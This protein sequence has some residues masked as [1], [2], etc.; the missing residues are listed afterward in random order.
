MAAR[1]FFLKAIAPGLIGIMLAAC[2]AA[3]PPPEPIRPVRVATVTPEVFEA[4][5]S[6]TG[7]VR[8]RYET[9]LAFR[10][11]GKIVAR[12]VEIGSEVKKGTLLARLDPED[13][14]L[15]IQNARAQVSAAQAN[16]NQAK[17]ELD[18]YR[19]LFDGKVVS[20]A[21]LD[22]RQNTFN[23]AEAQLEAAR[24]QLR[25]AQNQ[26]DYTELHADAD[27]VITAIGIEAGQVVA[28]GQTVMKLA[29]P[30]EKEVVFNVAENRL[31]ELRHATGIAI[32]LWAQPDRE[33]AGVVRE[34]APGADPVTRTYAVKVSVQDAPS[35]MRLGMTAT[36]TIVQ[37]SGESVVALP[38]S[39][40]YQ[41][42]DQPAVWIFSGDEAQG[43][44]ELRPVQVAAYVEHAV[45]IAA[46]LKPGE[47]VV[48]AGVHKLVPGQAVRLLADVA[49]GAN[50]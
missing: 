38:L 44:V 17:I 32:S 13:T 43:T 6:Y 42:G 11:G 3:A 31:D 48:T 21:E 29:R 2:D 9:N 35:T 41:K 36:V 46:G 27:G 47:K 8:A 28:A 49:A 19:K 15:A 23:T 20:Q 18:R 12:Y 22:R 33:Y 30:E 16:Y 10:V 24:S 25:V 7:E 50:S 5:S 40:L 26:M 37:R 45:L 1:A 4:R 34:I 39:A 14:R